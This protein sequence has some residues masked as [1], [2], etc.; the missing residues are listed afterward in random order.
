[1]GK[2]TGITPADIQEWLHV[3]KGSE[4][5]HYLFVVSALSIILYIN[6]VTT[7]NLMFLIKSMIVSAIALVMLLNVLS[8]R[9]WHKIYV[10]VNNHISDEDDVD[11]ML[12]LFRQVKVAKLSHAI[13]ML[14]VLVIFT[15][16]G[17]SLGI[18]VIGDVNIGMVLVPVMLLTSVAPL[19]RTEMINI[20]RLN[21][22]SFIVMAK[23]QKT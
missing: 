1:M 2:S 19:V 16:A 23:L 12:A 5:P 13:S 4:W 9:V 20:G 3:K 22:V 6:T 8:N 11:H 10:M 15:C 21:I 7:D 17:M 14:L 18:D